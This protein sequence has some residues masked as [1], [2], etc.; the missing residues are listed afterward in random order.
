[1]SEM[2]NILAIAP[3]APPKNTAEAIQVW[4]VMRE[5]DKRAQGRLV[6]ITPYSS[7]TWEQSDDSL[8]LELHHFDTHEL[9]LPWHRI[10]NDIVS[11]SRLSRFH[12]PDSAMWIQ[13]KVGEV[14]RALPK[15]YDLIYSRS[16]PMSGALLAYKLKKA[17]GIPWVMHIS[18]PWADS[19]YKTFH[20]RDAA[21][22]AKC[23]HAAD[24]TALTTKGQAEYYQDKYPDCA[25]R[26]FVS[27]NVM[28]DRMDNIARH[29][30]GKLHIVF[31]GRLY[32]SRSPKPLIQA[33]EHLRQTA[34]EVLSRLQIDFYGNAQSD[35]AQMLMLAPDVLTFHG[36]VPFAQANAAQAMAD[37]V[38][39]IEPDSQHP[40]IQA[41]LLS[42]VTDCM[43]QGQPILAITPDGSETARICNEGYGWAIHPARPKQLAE[44][45]AQLVHDLP[46][47]RSAPLKP[48]MPEYFV[49][50]V[51][52]DLLQRMHALLQRKRDA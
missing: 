35:A 19:L 8:N 2:L 36:H 32:G 40:L 50:P 38:F 4:R 13:W 51:V 37:I 29:T 3:H 22:E 25:E 1:M 20:P 17:L 15:K 11:S 27:P 9:S 26:I 31:A 49:E 30:D 45:I 21:L 24:L 14:I 39:A 16:S 33:I 10:T 42:K 41:I 12:I 47:L 34:P 28:P 44:R 52:Q 18:D 43:A 23:F 6:K 7:S 5:L 48:P 46:Q